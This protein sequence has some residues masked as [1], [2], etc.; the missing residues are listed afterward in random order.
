MVIIAT[1]YGRS[2]VF[3]EQNHRALL[4]WTILQVSEPGYTFT[5]FFDV[6]VLP[7]CFTTTYVVNSVYEK[8]P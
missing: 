6:S 8:T 7:G 2:S 4:P 1:C 5:D 3:S